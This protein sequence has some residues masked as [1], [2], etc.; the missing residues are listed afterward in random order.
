M[1]LLNYALLLLVVVL[2]FYTF[3]TYKRKKHSCLHVHVLMASPCVLMAPS[4][5][6]VAQVRLAEQL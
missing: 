3:Y 6:G 1:K 2:L 4:C 5:S